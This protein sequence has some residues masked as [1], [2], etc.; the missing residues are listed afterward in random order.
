MAILMDSSSLPQELRSYLLILTECLLESPI[1]RDGNM[2]SYEDVVTQLESD[3]VQTEIN[4]GLERMPRF[5]CG[6]YSETLRLFVQVT[7]FHLQSYSFLIS[8]ILLFTQYNL[9][10]SSF[11]KLHFV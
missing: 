8:L 7:K 2:I 11:V 10:F 1:N 3:T 4:V 5:T 9:K 6:P